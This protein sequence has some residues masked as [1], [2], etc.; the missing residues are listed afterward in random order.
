VSL[1]REDDS[2]L[3]L[4]GWN[5]HFAALS[6]AY[7][8][9]WQ[10]TEDDFPEWEDLERIP[11]TKD[12]PEHL[13]LERYRQTVVIPTL[14]D[15]FGPQM[16][17]LSF[18]PRIRSKVHGYLGSLMPQIK[19]LAPGLAESFGAAHGG[20]VTFQDDYVLGGFKIISPLDILA[21]QDRLD[22]TNWLAS[23]AGFV[24][25]QQP[26]ADHAIL[27]WHFCLNNMLAE[28][29]IDPNDRAALQKM[30]TLVAG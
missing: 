29:V 3:S 12:H 24:E 9:C 2:P 27:P 19:Q 10:E 30:F 17:G 5:Q 20:K 18:D 28:G 16:L 8:R 4:D 21:I 15:R 25:S 11:N 22:G 26:G 14:L 1:S 23:F 7:Q 13:R 6:C